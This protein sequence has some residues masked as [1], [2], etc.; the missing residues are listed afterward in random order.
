MAETIRG[1]QIDLS[2]KDMGVQRTLTDIRRSFRTLNSDLKLSS[3]NFQYGEKSISSYKARIKDLDGAIKVSER[4]VKDLKRQYEQVAKEQG[5][6]SAS[7]NRLRQ[8]Y[9]KQANELNFLQRELTQTTSEYKKVE[10]EAQKMARVNASSVGRMGQKFTEIGPKI[11][12]IGNSMKNFGRQM[13]TN[14]SAPISLGLGLAIKKSADFNSE[15]TKV[16]AIAGANSQELKAMKNEAL[17]LGAK[18]S[19]SAS[20]VSTGMKELASLGFDAKQT[21]QAMPGVI[22]ATEASGADLATTATVMASTINQFG[23]KAKD[24]AH[25]ADVLAMSANK[26]AADVDYMGEALKYA[27]TPAHTLGMS[28][29]DTSASIMAMSNA[30]LKGEQAGTTLRASLTRLAKPTA[31]SKAEMDKLGISLT[32]SKGKFVGMPALIGQFK[33][34]LQGMTK[35][36]KLATVSQIVGQESA[37]GF[38]ALIEAGPNKIDKYSKSLKNSNGESAK[39]AKQMKKNLKGSLEQLGGA[40]ETLGINIGDTMTPALNTLAKW[41]TTLAEKFNSAPQGVKTFITVLAVLLAS[42]GP[43]VLALGAFTASMGAIIGG[44]GSLITV[45]KGVGVASRVASIGMGIWNGVTSTARAVANAYRFAVASL[46]TSQMLQATK[47][48]IASMATATWTTV[49]KGA[50]LATRG[51]GLAVRF[52]TG[53]I[54]LIITAI[55]LLVAGIIH[56]W[57]TN[58]TFRNTIITIW[59]SIKT[60]LIATWNN[61]K[62]IGIVVWNG[63]KN[64]ILHPIRTLRTSISVVFN[65]IKNI[66]VRVWNSIKAITGAIVRG[67]VAYV[68][69]QFNLMK[70]IIS[71]VLGGIRTIS[72]KIWNSIKNTAIRLA[73]SLASGVRNNFNSLRKGVSNIFNGIRAITLRVWNSIKNTAVRLARSLS[74]GVRNNFNALRKAVSNIFNGIRNIASKVWSSIRSRVVSLAKSLYNGVKNNFYNLLKSGRS[75][76]NSIRSSLTGSFT[77]TKNALVGLARTIW[78]KVIGNFNSL[79]DGLTSVISKIKSHIGGMVNSV[80]GGLNKLIDGVN[81]VAG[82]LG[83]DKLPKIKLHTGTEHTNTTRNVVKNGK[84][85]RDTFATV[86]D[87]GRGNGPGGF[88]HEMIRYPNGKTAITP[89]RD[90]TAFLPKGSSVYNGAQ[91]HSIL[92]NSPQFSKGTL[93]RFANGTK[94]TMTEAVG[95]EAGKLFNKSK[96]MSHQALDTIGAKTKQAKDWGS[97]KVDQ[98]KSAATK[99]KDWIASKIGDLEDYM[100]HPGKLLEK[101]LG[102]FGVNMDAFGIGKNAELPYNMMKGMFSKLKEAA[103][104][105][106]SGWLEDEF[107]GGGGTN[108]FANNSSYHWVRGWSP[109]GHAG[110]DYAA[111]VGTKIP[112]S[113][114]GKVIKSWQSPWGGGNETQIYDGSKYTHIFM[115][116][117]KRK[118]SAGQKVSQGQ[119]IGLTGNTGN[120]TGPHLHWQVNKGKGFR[121]NHPDSIDPLK[122]AKEAAK[123]GGKSGGSRRASAWRPEV[124]K[125][126]KANGLPTSSAY[127]NAWIRQIQSESGGNAGARQGIKDVNSGGNEAQGLVQVTPKTFASMKLPGHGNI[128]NGLDNLMAGIHWAK[129]AYGKR[130][131]SVIGHGHGYATGGVINSEGWYNLAEGGY[132]EV[133]IPT[134]PSR[135]TDAMKLLAYASNK[136]RGK[137]NKRPKDLPNN[138]SNTKILNNGNTDLIQ[139]MTRQLEAQQTQIDLLTQLVTSNQTIANKPV[140]SERDI[141]KAQGARADLMAWS[142]GG[143]I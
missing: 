127:V 2:L 6:N 97:E 70:R 60:F 50:T 62:A 12:G 14:I 113:I 3:K 130:M 64:G 122:W 75:I 5:S 71:A 116:Q 25:I 126:L 67:Y 142:M 114:D 99:S 58:A 20:E 108:P 141:S 124:I 36:Q 22:S 39:T 107:S 138:T 69:G 17:D 52:M 8:E 131:L 46:T 49:T 68:R 83:M 35:E 139:V 54:G 7:A 112:S 33:N 19:L 56:L 51:L 44:V 4:N 98:I 78:K 47:S 93:P 128:L 45:F 100:E 96:K 73:K 1:M 87:K 13:T 101:V 28:L 18:T 105:L 80:K 135:S 110:I 59:N 86:G 84:I 61:L 32:D 21:M 23:M 106:I 43:I 136:I 72:G 134:D 111:S 48:K 118:V 42:I 16:G 63:I 27:G 91:T 55:G 121:N 90:T 41:V 123:A 88:R 109:S 77:R 74:S 85:A 102:A 103:K 133:V 79:R 40:F 89:N 94:K 29:E 115:H 132:P 140:L 65:G 11:Q 95:E 15:M 24:S 38:L 92:S 76:F 30:G 37:S 104:N 57:R 143:S 34:G 82:K 9:N 81:W 31:Q 129:T 10:V 119:I 120:S 66:S 125:A 53:P 117:S 26:S 137:K